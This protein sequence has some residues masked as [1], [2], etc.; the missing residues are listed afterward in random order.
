M[1]ALREDVQVEEGDE[2]LEGENHAIVAD[3]LVIESYL[4]QVYR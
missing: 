2:E 1:H 4:Y 3:L